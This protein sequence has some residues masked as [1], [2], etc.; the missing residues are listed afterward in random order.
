MTRTK[1][2]VKDKRKKKVTT[3]EN[4]IRL[5]GGAG[6]KGESFS[7]EYRGLGFIF[8]ASQ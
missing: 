8:H 7:A 5:Q 3:E 4:K 1:I 2:D 6:R